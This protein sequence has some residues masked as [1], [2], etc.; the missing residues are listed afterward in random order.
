MGLGEL[1]I[2][3][4]LALEA[5]SEEKWRQ[6]SQVATAK[7]EL[8]LAGECLGRAKDYGGLLLLASSAGSPVLMNKLAVESV[9]T[10]QNNVAFASN[11]LLGR[12]IPIEKISSGLGG[13]LI[14]SLGWTNVWTC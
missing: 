11:F 14:C 12:F 8:I 10:G 13:P 2:A 7:S 9:Q 5:D 4:E 1:K 6:L 3:Y